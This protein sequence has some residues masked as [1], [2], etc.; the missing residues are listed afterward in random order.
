MILVGA[1]V[2]GGGVFLATSGAATIASVVI[3]LDKVI[4][5]P[6]L[7]GV[8]LSM[9]AVANRGLMA[10]S[11]HRA[12]GLDV[13]L[14]AITR[15]A[16]VSYAAN[17]VVRIAGASGLAVFIRD[18]RRRGLSDGAVTGAYTLMSVASFGALAFLL[19]A[20]IGLLALT[21]RLAGWWVAATIGFSLYA[22]ALIAVAVIVVRSRRW[23]IRSLAAAG[24]LRDRLPGVPRRRVVDGNAVD[25]L[26][27]SIALARRNGAVAR[28][29]LVH[30]FT[31]KL[32]GVLML[33]VAASAAGS[34]ISVVNALIIYAA[35]VAASFV[36]IAPAGAGPVE[37]SAAA[38]LL[39]AGLTLPATAL[40]V[41]LFRIFDM[42]LPI[43]VGAYL[44]WGDRR[45]SDA[46]SHRG[47]ASAQLIPTPVTA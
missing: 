31:S 23:V 5:M 4:L 28:Q 10:W 17:K 32:L 22:V 18:G 9:G 43:A 14:R 44:G 24:K 41:A 34:P 12:V 8:G 39:A 33:L 25:D 1:A 11:A 13:D 38:M 21:G 30:G 35:S 3:G 20:A 37:A 40:T 15:T 45:R 26:Y 16:T 27:D 36:S 7:L 47:G 46:E 6:L 42:W 19:A 2:V 29:V